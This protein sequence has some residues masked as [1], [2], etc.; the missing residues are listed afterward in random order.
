MII[1]GIARFI[2]WWADQLK[3]RQLGKI[4]LTLLEIGVVLTLIQPLADLLDLVH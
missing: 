2:V 4:G 1:T 3:N